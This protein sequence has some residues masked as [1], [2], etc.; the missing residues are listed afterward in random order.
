[1]KK[2]LNIE[3]STGTHGKDT[4]NIRNT[5]H[6]KQLRSWKLPLLLQLCLGVC[7]CCCCCFYSALISCIVDSHPGHIPSLEQSNHQ[8]WCRFVWDILTSCGKYLLLTSVSTFSQYPAVLCASCP[9]DLSCSSLLTF[10]IQSHSEMLHSASASVC[11]EYMCV[12]VTVCICVCELLLTCKTVSASLMF[13]SHCLL[14][15]CCDK[16]TECCCRAEAGVSRCDCGHLP[17]P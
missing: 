9:A 13:S 11:V 6:H 1:M 17:S 3:Y 5:K 7:F 2:H 8:L 14:E 4:D 16:V 12:C 15:C 10:N